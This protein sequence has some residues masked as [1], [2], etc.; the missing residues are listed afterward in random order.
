MPIALITGITGQDGS[1]LTELL[2]E[3]GY[4]IHGIVR[5]SSRTERPRID[6]LTHDP[7]IYSSRLFLHYADLQDATTLRRILMKVGPDEVYHLAGQTH[8]GISFEIPEST[9]EFTAMGALRLLE[10]LRDLPKPPKVLNTGS[11]EMFGVPTASPQNEE[12]PYRPVTPYGVAKTFAVNMTHVY[13]KA[14]GMFACNAICY[15]HESPRRGESFVTRKITRAVARIK[16]G[17]REVLR[18]G[19][20]DASRDWGFAGDYIEAMW[21]MLQQDVPNDYILATGRQT[22]VREFLE[23]AFRSVGL[24]WHDHVQVDQGQFRA[25]DSSTLVGDASKARRVLGWTPKV[26]LPELVDMM[27]QSDLERVRLET[28]KSSS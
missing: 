12:T 24:N 3:K 1:Y 4:T 5:R 19:N 26:S 7:S 9:C 8:V 11:S 2:L 6:H 15:N 17:S 27:V 22:T 18:L 16:L 28:A 14:F 23:L 13:R 20:L 10:I 21:R 25:A